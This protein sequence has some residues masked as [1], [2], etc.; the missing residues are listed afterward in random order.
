M[1]H[2]CID[3][4]NKRANMRAAAG[5]RHD[6]PLARTSG[7]LTSGHDGLDRGLHASPLRAC[8][9]GGTRL[10]LVEEFRAVWLE[11]RDVTNPEAVRQVVEQ[12]EAS[13]IA[14][15]DGSAQLVR[16]AG[17]SGHR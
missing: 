9:R 10:D 3:P 6:D 16:Q 13:S 8:L 2:C 15:L 12:S 14:Q 1:R 7:Q 5:R 17:F 4:C 11:L